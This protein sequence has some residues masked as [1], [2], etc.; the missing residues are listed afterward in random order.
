FL[1]AAAR[2]IFAL[3]LKG[4]GILGIRLDASMNAPESATPRSTPPLL[5]L[6]ERAGNRLP[7]PVTLFIILGATVPAA[8]AIVSR[9]GLSVVHPRD[10]SLVTAINLLD[11]SGIQ[12]IFSEAVR[13]FVTFPPLGIVLAAMIGVGV[14]ERSGL[15]AAALQA[16]VM[17]VPPRF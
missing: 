9:L 3:V 12:R 8:S 2:T 15:I 6:V 10:G 1:W 17:A 5:D 7:H 11:R 4:A 16:I 14:A 13:N